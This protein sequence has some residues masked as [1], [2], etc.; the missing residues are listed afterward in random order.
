MNRQQL[1]AARAKNLRKDSKFYS[2][3]YS[4]IVRAVN[5][6]TPK[7]LAESAAREVA[8]TSVTKRE[9]YVHC[10]V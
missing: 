7:Q 5:K 4:A 1:I 8:I 6:M 3:D 10:Q 2:D 9:I